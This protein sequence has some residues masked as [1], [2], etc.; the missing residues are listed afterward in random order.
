VSLEIWLGLALLLAAGWFAPTVGDRGFQLLERAATRLAKHKSLT[1]LT[2]GLAAIL[3]RLAL[4][5]VLPVPIPA[6][7]DEFSYLLAADTF[8]HGRLANPP[9][10]MAVFFDTFHV[11]QHP[12]YASKYLPA[13]GAA[14]AV[15]QLLGAPW[16]GNLLTLA[17]MCMAMTWML[18]GWFPAPWA[19]LGGALVLLRI[20][21]FNYWIDGYLG[22]S[23]AVLGAALVLGA[24]PRILKH[25]RSLDPLVMGLGASLLAC[26][27]PVEGLIFCVPVGIALSVELL[28]KRELSFAAAIHRVMLPLVLAP[29]AAVLFL[30]YYNWRVTHSPVVFPYALYQQKYLNYPVFAWQKAK[31]PL[32]YAN[33]QFEVFFNDWLRTQYKLT[34][35][36]WTQRSWAATRA[37]WYV[38][39]GPVLTVPFFMFP[40]AVHRRHVRFLLLQFL[41]CAAGLLSVI[42]F[43]PHYA[44]PL[45]AA[46]FV[47]LIFAMRHLRRVRL[48]G[49][50]VGIYWTR[51]VVV[52]A[53]A[54]VVVLA[55]RAA[56]EPIV[57]WNTYRANIA[58]ELNSLPHKHLILVEYSPDHNVH[59]EW[60]YNAADID[61]AKIVWA[62][63]IPGRDLAPLLAYF[64]DR[65][66]WVVRADESAPKLE[67]YQGQG[68]Q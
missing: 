35:T 68:L 21:L 11:L 5:P 14:L 47:L 29:T 52:L 17:G 56:R 48:R 42:W 1:I 18:Q 6:M 50:L 65:T 53:V 67:P 25:R 58:K 49:R 43:L 4:L 40:W 19:L 28:A 39:A 30:G 32:H 15:G 20:G 8:A 41:I 55:G 63:E 33:P 64:K 24:F 60:V 59:R 23:I 9:H 62:R 22:G 12:T 2:V 44:A 61:G 34:F 57:G 10:P 31:P 26:S 27:R 51:L 36:G 37:W 16:I 46:W 3:A 54:W 66:V 38:Y 7:H 13:P 45:A